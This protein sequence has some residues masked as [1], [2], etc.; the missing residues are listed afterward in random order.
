MI[1]HKG[2]KLFLTM[3]VLFLLIFMCVG[4]S[5][6]PESTAAAASSAPPEG[7]V[8]IRA[9]V[10]KLTQGEYTSVG[11]TGIENPSIDDFKTLII[12]VNVV[13]INPA[14]ER[15]ITCPDIGEIT[16]KLSSKVVRYANS[17]SMNNDSDSVVNYDNTLVLHTKG[18][19]NDALK[20]KLKG[21]KIEVSYTDL[22]GKIIKKA[23]DIA[24]VLQFV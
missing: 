13:G 19:G 8:T 4:C 14:K 2:I 12:G 3:K 10:V 21:L 5:P 16:D 7:G 17:S 1:H 9:Q 23:Y 6:K 24:D 15:K 11:K 22:N 18:I 20:S